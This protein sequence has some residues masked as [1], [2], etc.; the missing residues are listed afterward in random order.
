MK[1][2]TF[3]ANRSYLTDCALVYFPLLILFIIGMIDGTLIT[4]GERLILVIIIM[5]LMSFF[6]VYFFL[7]PGT[8]TIRF[9]EEYFR[10]KK[11]LFA[12]PIL[13]PYREI[14]KLFVDFGYNPPSPEFDRGR[15]FSAYR[16]YVFNGHEVI[17]GFCLN[18][19]ILKESL[20]HVGK[21]KVKVNTPVDKLIK[22]LYYPILE[23]CLTEKQK[24]DMKSK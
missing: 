1:G 11:N 6:F 5:I 19:S 17:C 10:Y 23:D 15:R 13:F 22:K 3:L 20:K 2:K 8:A 7:I 9:Y 21:S 14:T 12:K 24:R 16:C 4:L 18:R